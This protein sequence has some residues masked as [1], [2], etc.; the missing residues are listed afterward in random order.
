MS[1]KNRTWFVSRGVLPG[2]PALRGLVALRR[3]VALTGVLAV[4]LAIPAAAAESEFA[5]LIRTKTPDRSSYEPPSLPAR[6]P[7]DPIVTVAADPVDETAS[8]QPVTH[9]STPHRQPR[10]QHPQPHHPQPLHHQE[11]LPALFDDGC[12]AELIGSCDGGCDSLCGGCDGG[13]MFRHRRG[14]CFDPDLWFASVELMLMFRSGDHL[15]PLVQSGPAGPENL[16]T[17]FGG[18]TVLDEMTVGGRVTLGTWL[19]RG[20]NVSLVARGWGAGTESFAYDLVSDGSTQINRPFFDSNGPNGFEIAGNDTPFG[21]DVAGEIAVRGANRVYGGDIAIRQ[22]WTSG[23]GGR[24]EVLYGYQHMR[25]S[26]EL[27]IFSRTTPLA[28]DPIVT[29]RDTFDADNVFHGGQLGLATRY[30]EGCWSFDG[31]IKVAGGSIRRTAERTGVSNIPPG[32]G[33]FVNADNAGTIDDSTF[34]WVPEL[35]ATLGCRF[36]RNLDL[37]VGYHY[38]AMTD[39]LQVSGMIDRTV[40][41]N[42]GRPNDELRFGTYHVQ[43]I[44]FGLQCV[45]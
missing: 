29:L 39:A 7:D 17:S 4:S 16:A 20:R 15:P 38:I 31:L 12:G 3:P 18:E 23:L 8:V 45:Y 33:L 28:P 5:G 10:H 32:D 14:N 30:N 26:D 35:S 40:D 21:D 9:Y 22:L 36:T 43:G 42:S 41:P 19:D 2:L 13:T 6:R 44:H 27:D 34:G 1:E 24:V 11:P 25:M 37:T